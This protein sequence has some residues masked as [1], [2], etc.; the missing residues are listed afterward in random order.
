MEFELLI[1]YFDGR[2]TPEEAMSI[3]EWR[4]VSIENKEYFE[5]LHQSWMAGN[6]AQFVAPDIHAAWERLNSNADRTVIP[7]R[8][9][10]HR[11]IIWWAA[12]GVLLI[13]GLGIWQWNDRGIQESS[14]ITQ[15]A[16]DTRKDVIFPDSSIATLYPHSSLRYNEKA[17]DRFID[18]SGSGSFRIRHNEAHPWVVS[19]DSMLI[20]DIGTVFEILQQ[21]DSTS[22]RVT[23]GAVEISYRKDTLK[24]KAG[25][26][27][28]VA[29]RSGGMYII[30]DRLQGSFKFEDVSLSDVAVRLEEYYGV[31]VVFSQEQLKNLRITASIENQT[32][33]KVLAVISATFGVTAEIKNNKVY[34]AGADGH[35]S[36]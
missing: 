9:K 27:G 31:E 2:A 17:D 24:L 30:H 36:E 26:L 14:F 12:A 5:Q 18:F 25:Q 34:I 21:S 33:P 1:K 3:D 23:E 15:S 7:I 28:G 13:I 6:E 11:L 32:L 35:S 19:I 29:R 8:K 4:A 20:K 16:V 10:S 22:V